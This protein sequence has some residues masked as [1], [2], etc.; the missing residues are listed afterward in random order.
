MLAFSPLSK[1]LVSLALLAS[2]FTWGFL[3]GANGVRD[4]WDAAQTDQKLAV[5]TRE[6]EA[7][8][9]TLKVTTVYVE[10]ENEAR[11]DDQ[12]ILDAIL[13]D[14]PETAPGDYA[15]QSF[16]GLWNAANS[17]VPISTAPGDPDERADGIGWKEVGAQHAEESA[18]CRSVERQL[19]ALQGWV[20]DMQKVY[21]RK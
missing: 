1:I 19:T 17:G 3:K 10:R 18:Y 12:D 15:P 14:L 2:V 8:I 5:V 20:R 7:V 6:K 13:A 4:Q 16:V 21:D 9:S 11:R